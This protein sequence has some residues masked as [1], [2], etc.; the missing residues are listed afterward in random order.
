MPNAI[1]R[2]LADH[3]LINKTL[4]GYSP[5]NE[6]F[7]HL[8]KTLTRIVLGHAW[9]EDTLF[10]PVL[11]KEPLLERRF[12]AEISQEHKDIDFLLNAVTASIPKD[13][14]QLDAQVLQLRILLATHFKKE[15]DALFPL[16]EKI[17]GSEGLLNLG[18]EM[19]LRKADV[20]II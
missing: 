19:E 4:E 5:D 13:R 18:H 6:R 16:A 7:P 12:V 20:R 1:E 11:E 15:E 9:F 3:K 10:L 14:K 2:L 17:L 8:Q